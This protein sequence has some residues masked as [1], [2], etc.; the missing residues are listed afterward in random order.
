MTDEK[1][2]QEIQA[3]LAER[4][5]AVQRGRADLVAQIDDQLARYGHAAGPP[6]KRATKRP[7]AKTESRRSSGR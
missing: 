3:L 6:V 5:A 7:A 2:A 4:V 1:R